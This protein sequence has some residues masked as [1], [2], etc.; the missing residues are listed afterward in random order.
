M[1]TNK[2]GRHTASTPRIATP[3]NTDRS[4]GAFR[5]RKA[6]NMISYA[7]RRK[8]RESRIRNAVFTP[9]WP[10]GTGLLHL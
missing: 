3:S 7:E 6:A 8:K 2:S 9:A 5:R 4:L 10:S 1:R